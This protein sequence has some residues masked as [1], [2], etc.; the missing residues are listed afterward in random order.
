MTFRL[1]HV[2]HQAADV[3]ATHRIYSEILGLPTTFAFRRGETL[4]W[5][6]D[7]G[8]K[9]LLVFETGIP[10]RNDE[11]WVLRHVGLTV[12]SAAE[13]DRLRDRLRTAGVQVHI[14]DAGPEERLYFQDPNGVTVEIEMQWNPPP[15]NDAEAV[16][17]SYFTVT[18]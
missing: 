16:V 1:D 2:A 4:R 12:A 18:R 9:H 13:R 7:L 6:Y 3:A 15:Q 5:A 14:E 8:G 10:A 17:R 11:D